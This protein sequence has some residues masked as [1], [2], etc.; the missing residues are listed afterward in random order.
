[1]RYFKSLLLC[2]CLAASPSLGQ[3]LPPLSPFKL[4]GSYQFTWNSIPFGKISFDGYQSNP[5]YEATAS[6]KVTGLA[7]LFSSHKSTSSVKGEGLDFPKA[8]RLFELDGEK[9]G[10]PDDVRLTYAQGGTLETIYMDDTHDLSYRPEVPEALRNGISDPLTFVFESRKRLHEAVETGQTTVVVRAFDGKR[11]AEATYTI[12]GDYMVKW[13][14]KE[15]PAIKVGM[16]RK[17]IE[18]YTEKEL[19]KIKSRE[20]GTAYLYFTPDSAF[21][22]LIAT[23][24]FGLGTLKAELENK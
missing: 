22:P 16:I 3:D 8:Q 10:K 2:L 23:Y 5:G 21:I 24:E 6:L 12:L 17:P 4:N 13:Q 14:G 7:R 11:L 9:R 15:V 20:S 18:G 1:M 19:K